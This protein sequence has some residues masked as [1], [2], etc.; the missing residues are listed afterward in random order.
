M[1][2]LCRDTGNVT[3]VFLTIPLRQMQAMHQPTMPV[4]DSVP[5]PKMRS[6]PCPVCSPDLHDNYME[7]L[8]IKD[9][10]EAG[11]DETHIQSAREIKTRNVRPPR[12]EEIPDAR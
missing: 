12:G 7:Y 4:G 10:K 6:V 1:C 8:R 2:E 5:S 9:M 11:Y 3:R